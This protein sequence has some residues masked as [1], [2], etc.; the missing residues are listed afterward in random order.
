MFELAGAH[1]S[2]QDFCRLHLSSSFPASF[3]VFSLKRG[4]VLLISPHV[5]MNLQMLESTYDEIVLICVIKMEILHKISTK[6][7][8]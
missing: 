4:H 8:E 2:A 5:L 1:P 3:F 7:E 6:A